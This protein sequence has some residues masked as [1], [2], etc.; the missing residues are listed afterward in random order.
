MKKLYEIMCPPAVVTAGGHMILYSFWAIQPRGV[1]P[2]RRGVPPYPR[3]R[4]PLLF[5][6]IFHIFIIYL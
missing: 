4:P 1:P 6:F 5:L 3:G 2:Y